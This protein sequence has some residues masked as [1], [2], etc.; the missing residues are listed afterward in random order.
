MH[1]NVMEM[2]LKDSSTLITIQFPPSSHSNY[3]FS[4]YHLFSIQISHSSVN[5]EIE[6]LGGFLLLFLSVCIVQK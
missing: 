4:S 1:L 5:A 2:N 3:N 6:Y